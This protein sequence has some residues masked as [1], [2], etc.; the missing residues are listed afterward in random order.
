[1]STIVSELRKRVRHIHYTTGQRPTT[2]AVTAD[3]LRRLKAAAEPWLVER[4]S[5]PDGLPRL[6][7]VILEVQGE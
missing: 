3:E 1:M 5:Q 7:S 2:L 4:L 6:D